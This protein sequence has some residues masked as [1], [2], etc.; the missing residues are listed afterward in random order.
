MAKKN[1]TPTAAKLQSK[2]DIAIS[3]FRNLIAGL[4]ATNEEANAA[5]TANAEQIAILQDENAALTALTE[6]NDKIVQ[7]IENLLSV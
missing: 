6:K 2:S 4:K 5:K 1:V 7:N 3:A